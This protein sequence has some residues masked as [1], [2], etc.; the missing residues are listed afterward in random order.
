MTATVT[1]VREALKTR[2]E[3]ITGL[4]VYAQPPGQ[5][6]VPA[7]VITPADGDFLDYDTSAGTEDLELTVTLFVQR[8]QERS[9]TEALDAYLLGSTSVRNAVAADPDL[10][11]T[12]DSCRVRS[13]RNHGTFTYGETSY[14]GCELSVEVL[15]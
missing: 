10:G 7:A 6:Q 4:H 14:Y 8:G 2:L 13:A 15:L 9:S 12:V 1:Q 3:S 5:V 11:G